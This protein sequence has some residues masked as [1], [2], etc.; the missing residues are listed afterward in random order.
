MPRPLDQIRDG[1]RSVLLDPDEALGLEVRGRTNAAVL[2]PLYL[3]GDELH[4]VFTKRREDLRRH[5]GEISEVD[6]PDPG[7]L[8][9]L[10]TEDEVGRV[11]ASM[12]RGESK[13]AIAAGLAP[14]QKF[15]A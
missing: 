12:D 6:V 5:A 7:V 4:A 2:V 14:S 9:D 1:L 11:Q 10:D 15:F 8:I 13:E 3:D